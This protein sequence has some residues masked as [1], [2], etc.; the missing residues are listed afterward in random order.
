MG[1]F[2]FCPMGRA[3]EHHFHIAGQDQIG[4]IGMSA[5]KLLNSNR[6]INSLDIFTD[7]GFYFFYG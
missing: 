3:P 5:Q 7:I 6:T 2:R 1:G 4:K